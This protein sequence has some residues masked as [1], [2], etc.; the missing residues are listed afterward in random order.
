MIKRQKNLYKNFFTPK[1]TRPKWPTTQVEQGR[2]RQGNGRSPSGLHPRETAQDGPAPGCTGTA[3]L[4]IR[5]GAFPACTGTTCLRAEPAYCTDEF[6]IN[7][8][9][10]CCVTGPGLGP[11]RVW[12]G[13]RAASFHFHFFLPASACSAVW[14]FLLLWL[15]SREVKRLVDI[16]TRPNGCA[17]SLALP[18]KFNPASQP[19][20]LPNRSMV[21]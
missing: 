1:Q 3:D 4:L 12:R 21:G 9:R 20:T 15:R 16:T 19:A 14:N 6:I 18:A 5:S 13:R 11:L 17:G 2:G 7:V 10:W 8:Q